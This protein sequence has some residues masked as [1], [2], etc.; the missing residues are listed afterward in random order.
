[1]VSRISMANA[2]PRSPDYL[3]ACA[4]CGV[5]Y[6]TEGYTPVN[7][8]APIW[9]AQQG[10]KARG[11]SGKRP[12]Y[13]KSML[14]S[15]TSARLSPAFDQNAFAEDRRS[16]DFSRNDLLISARRSAN[17]TRAMYTATANGIARAIRQRKT[18][19]T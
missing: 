15:S 17:A 12:L 5:S 13:S 4:R 9:H 11:F 8:R 10:G 7:G 6:F 18:G 2:N 19:V 16:R 3:F 14:S 1:M